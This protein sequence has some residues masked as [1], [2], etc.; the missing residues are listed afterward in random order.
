M[1]T[2]ASAYLGY[3]ATRVLELGSDVAGPRTT[4]TLIVLMVSLWTLIVL[5]RPITGWKLPLVASMAGL[6][7]LSLPYRSWGTRCSC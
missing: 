1:V 6:A 7:S 5:A 4:A 2:G 3:E